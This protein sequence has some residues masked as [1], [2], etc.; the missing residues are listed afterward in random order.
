MKK[1]LDKYLTLS[2]IVFSIL[3]LII[4]F[5]FPELFPFNASWIAVILC[6]VPI[7]K[8]AVVGLITEF[9]IKADVLV[10]IALIAS[11]IIGEVFAAAEIAVIMTLGAYLEE[12][13][14]DKAQAGIEK[15]ITLSPR[16]ARKI[17]GNGEKIIPLE[18]VRKNDTL[19][20]IA[21]ETIPVD[22]VIMNGQSSINQS[23]LTGEAIPV[24]KIRG[25]EVY[26]GTINQ[27]GTFEMKVEKEEKDSSLQKMIRLVESADAESAP[28]VRTADKWATWIVVASLSTAIITWLITKDIL[29]AVTILVVFCPCALVLA[30][31][32]AIIAAIGNATKHGVLIKSGEGLEKLARVERIMFDKTGTITYG[33]PEV[34]DF[35]SL[36]E[37]HTKEEVLEIAAIV[38]YHSEHP[39]GKAIVSTVNI[40]ELPISDV[41]NLEVIPGKGLQAIYKDSVIQL[42]N[43]KL[44]TENK[45]MISKNSQ[46]E[47]WLKSKHTVIFIQQDQEVIGAIALTDTVRPESVQIIQ[48]ISQQ[49]AQ[50]ILLTGDNQFIAE[51]VAKQ[52]GIKEVHADCLPEDKLRVIRNLQNNCFTV[53]M[54]G[55]GIN[56]APALKLADIGIAMGKN[57][58][59]IAIDAADIVLMQDELK[60]LPYLI[61]LAKKTLKT[62]QINILLAMGLNAVAVVL[63]AVGIL[64]PIA[65]ALVHNIGSV[66]VIIHSALLLKYSAEKNLTSFSVEYE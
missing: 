16:T 36:S 7:I 35:I 1:L 28:I 41:E 23:L 19:R 62:I 2:L 57:G 17:T 20:V 8:G 6:G 61:S 42:G 49:N 31:P 54:I 66:A 24:D 13:T 64:G 5:L 22:G 29:R 59:D 32:T 43:T 50:P 18:Q 65:G 63:A 44:L 37:T 39:L 47:E 30:T 12:L 55:D 60:E 51:E 11:V 21:G 10:S 33:Q 14:V 56:D 40:Q 26:S 48:E 9:D 53:A 27:Y 46:I 25:D 34:M 58:S 45:T 38:E 52:T 15:L 3:A 4:G